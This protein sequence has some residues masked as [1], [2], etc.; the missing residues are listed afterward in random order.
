MRNMPTSLEISGSGEVSTDTP[1]A[2]PSL[3]TS[4]YNTSVPTPFFVSPKVEAPSSIT[5][6]KVTEPSP[7]PPTVFVPTSKIPL[8]VR[9]KFVKLTDID[10]PVSNGPFVTSK[11][12]APRLKLPKV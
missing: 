1:L 9:V 10:P 11:V 3:S 4:T 12:C 8:P 6:Y 2:L 7:G 5:P